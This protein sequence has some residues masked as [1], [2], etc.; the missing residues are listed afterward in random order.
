[1][2][3]S[4]VKFKNYRSFKEL[5]WHPQSG[6]HIIYGPNGSGKSNLLEGISTLSSTRSPRINRDVELINWHSLEMVPLPGAF[7][8]ADK[9]SDLQSPTSHESVEI[10]SLI[11]I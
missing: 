2:R 9:V 10:L 8:S 3:L 7:M 11:H 4:K 6:I 5:E 1:M